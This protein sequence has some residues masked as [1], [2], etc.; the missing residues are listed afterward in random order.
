VAVPAPHQYVDRETSSVK[1]ERV[2]GDRLV[3]LMYGAALE[4]AGV[5]FKLLTSARMSRLLAH[6]NYDLPLGLGAADRFARSMGVDLTEC[7]ERRLD[8]PRKLFERQIRYWSVRPMEDEPSAVVSPA[9]ARVLPGSLSAASRV[10]LKGKFFE[11]EEL[12]GPGKPRW[13]SAF[14]DGDVAIFRLTPDKYHYNHTPVAGTVVDVYEVSGDY[15]SCNPGAVVTLA[16]PY[17]KNRRVV[18]I[19]DTD[20]PGGTRAGLVAMIE[21]V[22]LMIGEIVQCYSETRYERPC[23]VVPGMFLRKGQPK[24]LYRP[25]SSTDVVLFE[26]GRVA[27]SEDLLRNAARRDVRSRFSHGF[28]RPLVETDVKARST[29][30]RA[31]DRNGR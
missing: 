28:G 2:F 24:S 11:F 4:N 19:V 30:G 21:V 17:S 16:A 9:D 12:I 15:H 31:L 8:T 18:T 22:A 14:R 29:I 26:K 23:P 13:L 1:T 25:G 6:L 10:F 27:F 7:V 5:L 3:H 20:V